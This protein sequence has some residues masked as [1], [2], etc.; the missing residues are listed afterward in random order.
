MHLT[1]AL[2]LRLNRNCH[3]GRLGVFKLLDEDEVHKSADSTACWKMQKNNNHKHDGHQLATMDH[4]LKKLFKTSI[5]TNWEIH[6]E[7]TS[8]KTQCWECEVYL[9]ERMRPFAI[10]WS[11]P[12][13]L[14]AAWGC[15]CMWLF[16]LEANNR[17]FTCHRQWISQ[18]A[19]LHCLKLS[20]HH[21]LETEQKTR[22]L[23]KH[24]KNGRLKSTC[25]PRGGPPHNNASLRY[26][27]GHLSKDLSC[28]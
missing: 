9:S 21:L 27:L 13:I 15:Q 22:L 1:C 8:K 3:G 26:A 2:L 23:P 10:A 24:R 18:D 11:G 16:H 20:L 17:I 6:C 5:R 12:W 19:T 14:I 4:I 7:G 28:H 25:V